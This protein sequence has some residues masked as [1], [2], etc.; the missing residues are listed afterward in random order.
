MS[1]CTAPWMLEPHL[2]TLYK[3][4]AKPVS[5][6]SEVETEQIPRD[7]LDVAPKEDRTWQSID[8][9]HVD[10]YRPRPGLTEE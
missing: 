8:S 7:L 9:G 2:A 4:V 5:P 1:S 3:Q 6:G 10:G